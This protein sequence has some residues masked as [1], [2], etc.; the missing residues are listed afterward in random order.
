MS[1]IGFLLLVDDDM[2]D[3]QIFLEALKH[4]APSI[5]VATASNG[6]EALHKLNTPGAVQPDLIFLDLNMPMMN[7]KEL[8]EELKKTGTFSH[9]PVII[10]TTS[11]RVEDREESIQLGAYS[12]LVKPHNFNDLC[13]Q[14][15]NTLE[16]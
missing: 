3:Q 13:E 15:R 14:L 16:A 5:E 8:L 11:S 7:G 6:L 10:Y 4:V 12:Y 2:D 1:T 9:I